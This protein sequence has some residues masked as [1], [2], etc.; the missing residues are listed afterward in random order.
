[1]H[2]IS[3]VFALIVSLE[4][5]FIM[6]LEMFFSTSK[7]AQKA[8]GNSEEFLSDPGVQTLFKNQGLYNGFLAA[9]IIWGLF[10]LPAAFG[11]QVV[12]FFVS[13]VLIA[14]IYGGLTANKGI[15]VKQGIPAFIALLALVFLN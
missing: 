10:F 3:F 4:H 9:G 12:I 6:T 7:T 1:M 11:L 13:C 2:W 15:I 14:A 5:F 8:F